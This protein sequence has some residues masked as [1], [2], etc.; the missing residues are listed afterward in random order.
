MTTA[1]LILL[2]P[3]NEI[4]VV[5][6]KS[7]TIRIHRVEEKLDTILNGIMMT[8]NDQQK[9]VPE[10]NDTA[11]KVLDADYGP[12]S[13]DEHTLDTYSN[14]QGVVPKKRYVRKKQPC[15]ISQC[16]KNNKPLLLCDHLRHTHKLSKPHRMYWL[17]VAAKEEAR[18]ALPVSILGYY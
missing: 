6:N 7:D 2:F 14:E 1:P 11:L 12:M 8:L 17:Y 15:P 10:Y 18:K 5:P 13:P 3:D 16:K 4:V 9:T